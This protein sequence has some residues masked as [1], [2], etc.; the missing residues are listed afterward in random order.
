[1]KNASA[2]KYSA[3]AGP[4]S[5]NA[6]LVRAEEERLKR[7]RVEYLKLKKQAQ[8]ALQLPH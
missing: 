2:S 8:K 6:D 4:I 3:L 5:S 1:M 7:E